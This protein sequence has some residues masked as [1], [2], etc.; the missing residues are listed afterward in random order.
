MCIATPGRV[1]KV[2]GEKALVDF[3]SSKKEVWAKAL[4]PKPG[5]KVLVFGGHIIEVQA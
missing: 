1:L 4:K 5:D 2:R 3:G